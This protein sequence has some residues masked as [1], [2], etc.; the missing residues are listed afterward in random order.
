M[1]NRAK[2]F[3]TP[4][5]VSLIGQDGESTNHTAP[6][7]G[8]GCVGHIFGTHRPDAR[9]TG[10]DL[11]DQAEIGIQCIGQRPH[12]GGITD[13]PAQID[14]RVAE[15]RGRDLVPHIGKNAVKNGGRS[16]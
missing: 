11:R 14:L 6:F 3:R 5:K 9:R 8:D 7:I 15:L 1:A 10:L 12:R 13:H 2:E 16:V 4:P